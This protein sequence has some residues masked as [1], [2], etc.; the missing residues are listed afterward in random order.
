V[1][2][3]E[4]EIGVPGA[5]IQAVQGAMGIWT[6][7]ELYEAQTCAWKLSSVNSSPLWGLSKQPVSGVS[8]PSCQTGAS[9][10]LLCLAQ[11]SNFQE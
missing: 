2:G 6:A 8:V 4:N 7:P 10:F 11:N 5:K 9:T 1:Q 3:E